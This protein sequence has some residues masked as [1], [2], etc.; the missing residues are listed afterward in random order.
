MGPVGGPSFRN[1][2]KALDEVPRTS[3]SR[4][5]IRLVVAVFGRCSSVVVENMLGVL[6]GLRSLVDKLKDGE[7]GE[8]RGAELKLGTSDIREGAED[9]RS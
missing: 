5:T 4:A 1:S 7:V 8:S 3:G 6:S 9:L 2:S